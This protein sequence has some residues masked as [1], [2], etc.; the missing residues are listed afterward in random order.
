[1]Q[2]PPIETKRDKEL[3]S[4][5]AHIL[6]AAL[7]SFLEKGYHQTGV[8]DIAKRAGVSLG[9]LY[10]HFSGKHAVLAEIAALEREEFQPFLTELSSDEAPLKVLEGFVRNYLIHLSAPEN[11]ILSLEIASEAVRKPD[12]AKMF[13]ENQNA[14]LDALAVLL[15]RGVKDGCFRLLPN[16]R[17]AA[18]L[19]LDAMEGKALRATLQTG[20]TTVDHTEL[21]DFIKNAIT[22][23]PN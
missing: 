22:C 8:R 14:L 19:I 6:E 12:I 16:T 17:E 10:N 11:V 20:Q 1:M 23:P 9:N 18:S 2:E 5:R 4:R 15:A 13:L 7:M 21:W 3:K